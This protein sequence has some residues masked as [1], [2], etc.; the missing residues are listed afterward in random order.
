VY[1]PDLT[2]TLFRIPPYQRSH[3]VLPVISIR[4][5]SLV[6]PIACCLAQPVVVGQTQTVASSGNESTSSAAAKAVTTLPGTTKSGAVVQKFRPLPWQS[7]NDTRFGA[8]LQNDATPSFL[9]PQS[10]ASMPTSADPA[11]VIAP[12]KPQALPLTGPYDPGY[13]GGLTTAAPSTIGAL[14]EKLDITRSP[15]WAQDR[16]KMR[17]FQDNKEHFG[18]TDP[19]GFF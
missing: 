14:H 18:N 2:G 12:E 15:E 6:L 13:F 7:K 3:Q 16:I 1:A 5:L 10:F 8:P 4:S 9:K 11:A 19:A 17:Y